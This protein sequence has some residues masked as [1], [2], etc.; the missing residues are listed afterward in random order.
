MNIPSLWNIQG[1]NQQGEWAGWWN[2]PFLLWRC[3]PCIWDV[4]SH[5][6]DE[7]C[8][9]SDCKTWLWPRNLKQPPL[10]SG[11][12]L[13][14]LTLM[15]LSAA[16]AALCICA[17]LPESIGSVTGVQSLK[18][19]P[20]TERSR[21]CRWALRLKLDHRPPLRAKAGHCDSSNNKRVVF[22]VLG[23]DSLVPT[24]QPEQ[25]CSRIT[26]NPCC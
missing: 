25:L 22:M 11:A 1:N 21:L 23:P 10:C 26:V 8:M 3:V 5:Y 16:G 13:C 18:P 24:C 19:R 17:Y 6:A 2:G 9:L 14:I 4:V 20:P 15:N 12:D 7:T